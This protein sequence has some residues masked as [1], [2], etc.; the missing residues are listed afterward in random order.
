MVCLYYCFTSITFQ[1]REPPAVT[2]SSNTQRNAQAHNIP[3]LNTGTQISRNKTAVEKMNRGFSIVQANEDFDDAVHDLECEVP[4]VTGRML[5]V[6]I[7]EIF[8]C[9][10]D[11]FDDDDAV[12]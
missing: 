2:V 11:L 5:H 3:L 1:G 12:S 9:I 6:D 10:G 8:N 7:L 4:E